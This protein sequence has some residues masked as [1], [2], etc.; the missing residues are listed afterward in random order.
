MTQHY[1]MDFEDLQQ[2]F[3]QEIITFE[4]FIDVL[5]DNFGYVKTK[6]ILK[7]NIKLARKKE[8]EEIRKRKQEASLVPINV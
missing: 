1:E 4:Q 3:I 6:M 8:A 2:A 5:N 7:K